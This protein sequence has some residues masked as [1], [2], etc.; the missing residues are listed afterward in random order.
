MKTLIS[1]ISLLAGLILPVVLMIMFRST[2]STQILLIALA[3]IGSGWLC[4]IVWASTTAIEVVDGGASET[5]K[6]AI[7]FGW[8]CPSVLVLLTFVIQ[9]FLR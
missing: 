2:A 3:A 7:K 5:R 4:N 9:L 6:I 8:I 1:L